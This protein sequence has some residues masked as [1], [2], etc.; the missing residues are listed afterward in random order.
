MTRTINNSTRAAKNSIPTLLEK[1]LLDLST[2]CPG[3]YNEKQEDEK[4]E[5]EEDG[6]K[7]EKGGDRGIGER[8]RSK[9]ETTGSIA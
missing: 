9:D 6:E 5:E 7:E 3:H 4:E 2:P 8:K 1:R